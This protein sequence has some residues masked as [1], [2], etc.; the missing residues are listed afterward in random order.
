MDYME[1]YT[2]MCSDYFIM[3]MDKWHDKYIKSGLQTEI[4][5]EVRPILI[6]QDKLAKS[7]ARKDK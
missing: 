1:Q 4:L 7:R 2:T 6:E 3:T 5:K